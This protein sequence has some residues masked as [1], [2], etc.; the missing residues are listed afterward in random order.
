[1]PVSASVVGITIFN[2]GTFGTPPGLSALDGPDPPDLSSSLSGFGLG[3]SFLPK[4]K[5]LY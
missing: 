2:G 5:T 4:E 3:A 1:M